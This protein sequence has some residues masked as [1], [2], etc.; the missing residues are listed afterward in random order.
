MIE[1]KP[2]LLDFYHHINFFYILGRD[3]KSLEKFFLSPDGELI[4]FLGESGYIHLVSSKVCVF[5]FL[6]KHKFYIVMTDVLWRCKINYIWFMWCRISSSIIYSYILS[7]FIIN[8]LFQSNQWVSS[9][10]MNGKV[11]T[12]T[13]SP[14]SSKL[15]S[16]GS[17]SLFCIYLRTAAVVYL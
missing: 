9:L 4:A 7:H 13:F 3:E 1:I 16:A 8:Y 2:N 11:N 12:A 14:D 5:Y 10:K 17:K 6:K 15:Y